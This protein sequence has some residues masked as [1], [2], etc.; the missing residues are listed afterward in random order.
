M[1]LS[2]HRIY[3]DSIPKP[4]LFLCSDSSKRNNFPFLFFIYIFYKLLLFFTD[5][6]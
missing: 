2:F 4:F 3:G 6:L 1:K 5:Y